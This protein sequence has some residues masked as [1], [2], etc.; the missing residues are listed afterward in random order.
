MTESATNYFIHESAYVDEDVEIG[1]GTKIWCFTHIAKGAVIGKNCTIGQ[2]CYIAGEIG[3]NCK[4]QNNV[5]VFKGVIITDDVFMGPGVITTNILRPR[6]FIN[7]KEKFE[8][9]IIEK[10]ATIGAGSIIVAGITVGEYALIG[11]GTTLT[12]NVLAYSLVYGCPARL[13]GWVCK[14]GHSLKQRN[15]SCSI[16]GA[17]SG[18]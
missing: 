5:S 13:K 10:G 12:R 15:F 4:I 6:A 3:N 1:E 8:R 17:K 18:G 16:C 9:T 7:Q 11:A 14:N 2:N